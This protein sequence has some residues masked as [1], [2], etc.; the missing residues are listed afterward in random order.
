VIDWACVHHHLFL[1]TL[2]IHTTDHPRHRSNLL[3]IGNMSYRQSGSSSLNHERSCRALLRNSNSVI[4]M[5]VFDVIVKPISIPFWSHA[6]FIVV[7]RS[8]QRHPHNSINSFVPCS[9]D[10]MRI[11]LWFTG[12]FK[13][14]RPAN[15]CLS[16]QYRNYL[17]QPADELSWRPDH[18]YYV[19][20]VSRLVNSILCVVTVCM[21]CKFSLLV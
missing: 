16:E 9:F 12:A 13:D 21:F 5:F 10:P 15:W 4:R 7:Q 20:M 18:D 8:V 11:L 14:I 17:Q 1:F 2:S 3:E 6:Y 19:H